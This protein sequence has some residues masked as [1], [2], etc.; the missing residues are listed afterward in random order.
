MTRD[1]VDKKKN[2]KNA[3]SGPNS[4]KLK[5]PNC[6]P[7]YTYVQVFAANSDRYTVVK[8]V[9]YKPIITRYIRIH[10]ESWYGHISMR[11]EFYGCRKGKLMFKTSAMTHVYINMIN[12]SRRVLPVINHSFKALKSDQGSTTMSNSI[13]FSILSLG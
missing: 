3:N 7:L 8:N 10:P 5:W 13:C 6:I 4:R 2:A 12:R 11:T 1:D 9:L